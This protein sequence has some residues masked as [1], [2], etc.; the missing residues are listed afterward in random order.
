MKTKRSLVIIIAV[1]A[2]VIVF[3]T[4]KPKMNVQ[5]LNA[6]QVL[7]TVQAEKA[8]NLEVSVFDKEGNIVYYKQSIKPV[9]K[10]N[11]IF[12]V[13]SLDNGNYIMQ[14]TANGVMLKREL[15]ISKSKIKVGFSE[16]YATPYFTASTEVLTITHLNFDNK[17][18]YLNIYDEKGLVYKS[19][20]GNSSPL[21]S[22]F[23]LSELKS[24]NYTAVLNSGKS[25]FNYQFEK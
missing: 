21:H 17:N 22:G 1:F 8:S 4:E 10:F 23:D 9:Q 5:P 13:E 19:K 18:Y 16:E 11:K 12:D 25:E 14:L 2:A 24:G 20:V 6:D 15:E 7:V 3:A